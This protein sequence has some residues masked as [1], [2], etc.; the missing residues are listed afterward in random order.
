M[1]VLHCEGAQYFRF[2]YK[3][4]AIIFNKQKASWFCSHQKQFHL[5]GA[6]TFAKDFTK[7][8]CL[9]AAFCISEP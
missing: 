5:E 3:I 2:L 1:V 7:H 4:E 9:W 8:D 6:S